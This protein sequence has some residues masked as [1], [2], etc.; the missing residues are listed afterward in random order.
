[1]RLRSWF[2]VALFGLL[3][4]FCVGQNQIPITLES[5]ETIF[6]VLTALNACGYDQDLTIS[7]AT[8]SNV[9]AEVQKVLQQSSEAQAARATVCDYYQTHVASKDPNRNLSQYLSLALYLDGPPHF[10]PRLKV[11]ELPPDAAAIAP[12]GAV[13]EHFYEK[14]GLHSIWERHRN[15]YAAAMNRYHEPLAKMVFDTE[16]YLKQPSS[17]YLGR[18]FTI[19]LDFM[20]SPNETDARNYGSAYYV[21]VFPA[22]NTSYGSAPQTALKMDQ[23]RHTFL[24]YEMDPLAEKHYSSI[25]RLQ[26]LLQSVKRAP[27]EEGFKTDISLLVT[28][29][30]VRAIEI[31]TMGNKQTAEAMR[32]QAVDDAVKQGYILTRYFYDAVAAFEKDPA[33]IRGAYGAF[34]DNVD[35]KKEER[36]AAAVQFASA[37]TPELVRLSRPEERRMLV[38]AEKRLAAGDPKGAQELAQQAL[39]KKIGDQGRALFILAEVAVANKNRDGAQDSFQK[40]IAASQDPMVLGWSHVYLGRILDMKEDREAALQEYQA[41]LNTGGK[42]PEIKAAAQR[43]LEKAYEP[44][45]KPQ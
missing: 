9:R 27:M 21:V 7:D 33:G 30:L 32:A 37:T 22:P 19:Y 41:A 39:D 28:E 18:T 44:P 12:F 1:M 26:P 8:R 35:L 24:H 40:A 23:I 45:P 31:R 15:D 6:S 11:E 20:G 38:T 43:G 3:T 14:V 17:Q 10:M 2:F 13:L 29:C 25:K 34:L 36:A 4:I 42:L 5:S 16:I